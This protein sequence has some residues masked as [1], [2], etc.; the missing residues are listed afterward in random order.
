M[1][2]DSPLLLQEGLPGRPGRELLLAFLSL[3]AIPLP[4]LVARLSWFS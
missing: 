1:K 3:H 2:W 4:V